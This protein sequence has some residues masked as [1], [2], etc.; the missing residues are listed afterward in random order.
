MCIQNGVEEF[1]G[2]PGPKAALRK[3]EIEREGR[4]GEG[5]LLEEQ[6]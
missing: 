3:D 5:H 1:P 6:R 2:G 4:Q